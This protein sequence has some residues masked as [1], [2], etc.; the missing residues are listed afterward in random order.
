MFAPASWGQ[1]HWVNLLWIQGVYWE[2]G[3]DGAMRHGTSGFPTPLLLPAF[4]L[5]P[6]GRAHGWWPAKCPSTRLGQWFSTGVASW[7][8]QR[9]FWLVQFSGWGIATDI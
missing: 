8:A 1:G 2:R 4:L 3:R 5:S 9:Y 7:Q 6:A